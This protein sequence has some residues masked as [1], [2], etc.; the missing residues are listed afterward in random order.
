VG[1]G[2][3]FW[4]EVTLHKATPPH[5]LP[6]QL[7]LAAVATASP[8]PASSV[9]RLPGRRILLVEDE[10]VNREVMHDL[11]Q[12]LGL[13]VESA[14]DG[15]IAVEMADRGGFDAILMDL[16]MPNLGGLAATARIRAL[17]HCAKVPIIALTANAFLEDRQECLSAGMD[18]FLSKP[19]DPDLVEQRL[20]HWLT[21]PHEELS[22]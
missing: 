2:S 20:T 15:L 7:P 13:Q 3:T 11:L 18:D 9:A 6:H 16:Q 10:P 21:R 19:V 14:E 17:P 8:A 22:R 1:I 12:S 4:F 5:Q